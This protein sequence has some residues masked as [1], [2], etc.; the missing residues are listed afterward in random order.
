MENLAVSSKL[1]AHGAKAH[2]VDTAN[3]EGVSDIPAEESAAV[4]KFGSLLAAQIALVTPK[5]AAGDAALKGAAAEMEG[6]MQD[7]ALLGMLPQTLVDSALIPV[8]KILAAATHAPAAAAPGLSTALANVSA[9]SGK[10]LPLANAGPVDAA[11]AGNA[12]ALQKSLLTPGLAEPAQL[13]F[14]AVLAEKADSL[15]PDA[16]ATPASLPSAQQLQSANL[17]ANDK[18]PAAGQPTLS[19][20]QRVGA[21]GWGAGLGDKVVWVVGNQMRGAEIHLNPPA[22]GPLEVRINITDGQANLSFMTHHTSVREAIEAATPRLREM[23]GDSGIGMGSVSV[24]VGSFAQQQQADSQNRSDT[25]W[26][27]ALAD[28]EFSGEALTTFVQPLRERG[29]VDF[30]A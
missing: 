18:V 19:V 26:P 16:P 27:Q 22:L 11:A 1:V 17:L 24:N 21:E 30:F 23:L 10:E 7:T 15:L 12:Q 20:P 2:K 5:E 8:Q 6:A 3:L 4:G 29:M 28:A 9:A 13:Q 14:G 25:S